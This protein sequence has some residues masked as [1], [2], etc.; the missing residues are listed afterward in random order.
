LAKR[1]RILLVPEAV[2][3]PDGSPAC[4]S[5]ASAAAGW[6]LLERPLPGTGRAVI[7]KPGRADRQPEGVM[8]APALNAQYAGHNTTGGTGLIAIDKVGNKVRFYDPRT[9]AEIKVVAPPEKTVHELTFSQDRRYAFTPLYGDGIYGNNKQPNNKVLVIDLE[10]QD[11][12]GTIDLGSYVA[13][14]GMVATADGKLWVVS[15]LTQT[16][17]LVDPGEGRIEDTYDVPGKGSHLLVLLPDESKLYVSNKEAGIAVFDVKGRKFV[18][19]VPIGNP[20]VA[21]GNG[22]G[23]EGI[24]PTPDG[25]RILAVDNDRSDIRVI[26]T[27]SDLEVDRVALAMHPPT[28]L[29]R[30]RVCKLMF[31]PDGRWLVVA[32]YATGLAWVIDGSDLSRQ[33]PVA[34]PKGP[35]GIAFAADG[36]AALVSSHDNG[37]IVRISLEDGKITAAYP[38]GDG[39]ECLAYY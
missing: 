33:T 20:S 25:N 22:S 16:L 12:S 15:D 2:L 30:T 23:S 28:N 4:A 29:S 34:V 11:I 1:G 26:D 39:I 36:R 27:A 5:A 38:G 37:V 10:R 14:H 17:L 32:S 7:R 18:A 8:S 3:F 6:R 13:P 35:F 9:L 24:T 31:S 21:A 19:T